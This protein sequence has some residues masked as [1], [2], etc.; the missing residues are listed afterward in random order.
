MAKKKKG[1]DNFLFY[2]LCEHVGHAIEVVTYGGDQYGPSQVC[3]ECLDCNQILESVDKDEE[4]TLWVKE[5]EL[6]ITT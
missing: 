2:K 6:L 4:D 3:I 1:K 5:I